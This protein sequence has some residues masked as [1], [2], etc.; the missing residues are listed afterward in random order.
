MSLRDLDLSLI[1]IIVLAFRQGIDGGLSLESIDVSG[2]TGGGVVLELS[3]VVDAIGQGLDGILLLVGKLNINEML[4]V[5]QES[6]LGLVGKIALSGSQVVDEGV[7]L[8][9][10][11]LLSE[12]VDLLLDGHEVVQV[13]GNIVLSIESVLE[14]VAEADHVLVAWSSDKGVGSVL[15]LGEL[16]LNV[17]AQGQLK[18][19]SELEWSL[20]LVGNVG[21]GD[22]LLNSRGNEVLGLVVKS[23]SELIS[24]T[25]AVG[26]DLSG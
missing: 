17:V 4:Q 18:G 26:L 15:A 22:E 5:G 21:D 25:V 19:K 8:A 23:G 2:K 12:L 11:E 9:R 6:K 3:K 20:G 16:V 14:L 24:S 1:L 13:L 7:L 10:D